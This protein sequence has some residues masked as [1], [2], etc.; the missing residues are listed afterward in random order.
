MTNGRVEIVSGTGTSHGSIAEYSCDQNYEV[1]G[2]ARIECRNGA[3]SA[4]IPYCQSK[5]WYGEFSIKYCSVF[6]VMNM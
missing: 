5:Y 2:Q 6:I 3:W 1:I 4:N